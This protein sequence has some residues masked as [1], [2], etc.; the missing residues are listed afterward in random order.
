MQEEIPRMA[1]LGACGAAVLGAIFWAI[2]SLLTG[3]EFA[4]VA[5]LVGVGVGCAS[6][7]L[8][9]RGRMMGLICAMIALVGI[10]GGRYLAIVTIWESAALGI[11]YTQQFDDG[12][13]DSGFSTML[14]DY[15]LVQSDAELREFMVK[16]EWTE[17]SNAD[18]VTSTEIEEFLK[19]GH[20][21]LMFFHELEQ[22]GSELLKE[23]TSIGPWY[24]FRLT[25][26]PLD[27]IFAILG[28]A[29]AFGIGGARDGEF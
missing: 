14:S 8:G 28:M 26:G 6:M 20:D 13:Y 7:Y 9:G 25:L 4:I 16:H 17:A 18:N 10:F 11:M 22:G 15:M 23:L 29:A 21:Y 3:F 12:Q 2:L 27:F 1:L 19:Y 5:T 24:I